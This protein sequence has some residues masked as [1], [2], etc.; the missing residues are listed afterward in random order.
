MLTSAFY[1]KSST[2]WF[3]TKYIIDF[4]LFFLISNIGLF[5]FLLDM[6]WL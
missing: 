5:E 4:F 2:Q 6:Q 3:P 1:E